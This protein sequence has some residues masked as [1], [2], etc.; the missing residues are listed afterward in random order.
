M[1]AS[2][3][4][5]AE[6][7]V[8]TA[9]VAVVNEAGLRPAAGEGHLERVDD[10]LG[11]HVFGHAPADDATRVGVLDGGEIEPALPGPQV[12]DVGDPED[13]GGLGA[14]AALDEI[15][16]DANAGDAD[17]R[18]PTLL[19]DQ[20]GDPGLAHETLDAL[21]RDLDAVSHAQLGVDPGRPVD[22]AVRGPDLLDALRQPGVAERAIRGRSG[23]PG[24][25]ARARDAEQP[26]GDGDR[27]SGLLGRDDPVGGHRVS[28]SDAKKAAARLSRSRSCRSRTFSRRSRRSSSRSSLVRPSS[29]SP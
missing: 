2:R 10:E 13:A 21:A 19:G 26:A 5:E 4:F 18:A 11:A 1:P 7:D 16:G 29:R 6:A 17:R 12:G 9:L 3:A 22:L 24:V 23:R 25:I 8:L 27:G 14:K 15:V 28:V 20:P